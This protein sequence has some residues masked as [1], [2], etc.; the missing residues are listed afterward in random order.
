MQAIK[1]Q[2]RIHAAFADKVVLKDTLEEFKRMQEQF[3]NLKLKAN[4]IDN[5]EADALKSGNV[6]ICRHFVMETEEGKALEFNSP[7]VKDVAQTVRANV[8]YYNNLTQFLKDEKE[9]GYVKIY[10]ALQKKLDEYFSLAAEDILADVYG[11][12]YTA[13]R[14]KFTADEEKRQEDRLKARKENAEKKAAEE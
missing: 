4:A 3:P 14:D 8:S 5:E 2:D 7:H 9:E 13:F 10:S 12:T 6:S 11:E 1:Y